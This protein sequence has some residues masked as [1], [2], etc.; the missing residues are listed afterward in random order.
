MVLLG[1][2]L[3]LLGASLVLLVAALVFLAAGLVFL[4]VVWWSCNS[5]QARYT[6]SKNISEWPEEYQH[7]GSRTDT[8]KKRKRKKILACKLIVAQKKKIHE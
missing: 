4:V 6:A 1:A 8:K 3:V 7:Q 2:A 5:T